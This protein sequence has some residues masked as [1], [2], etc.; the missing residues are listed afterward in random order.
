MNRARVTI[1]N[2]DVGPSLLA[3]RYGFR[4]FQ[5]RDYSDGLTIILEYRA[6]GEVDRDGFPVHRIIGTVFIRADGW[7]GGW[8]RRVINS[9]ADIGALYACFRR[10]LVT[11]GL[12]SPDGRPGDALWTVDDDGRPVRRTVG[13]R[14]VRARW[15]PD[16]PVMPGETGRSLV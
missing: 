12:Y 7:S 10:G 11:L 13:A 15:S 5:R 8:H 1:T 9:P 3:D 6:T 16:A 14:P 4:P 2:G